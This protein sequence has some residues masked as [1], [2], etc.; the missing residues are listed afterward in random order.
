[1]D[2]GF[3]ASERLGV[4][5]EKL[6]LMKALW[7][8]DEAEFQGSYVRLSR[9]WAWPKPLQKPHPPILWGG[10]AAPRLFARIVSSADGWIP[11]LADIST[12]QFAADVEALRDLWKASERGPR[13]VQVTVACR[14]LS[15]DVF[16]AGV[17]RA[18]ELALDRILLH[19]GDA[20]GEVVYPLL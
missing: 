2:H 14:T 7:T 4:V 15:A 13:D 12:P 5:E 19:V 10:R 16:M 17:E 20:P 3:A 1:E 18:T 6:A 8:Q 11:M 9:S